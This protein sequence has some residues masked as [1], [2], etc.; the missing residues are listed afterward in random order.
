MYPRG[1][2]V[3][4]STTL[5]ILLAYSLPAM[6]NSN[7]L[8]TTMSHLLLVDCSIIIRIEVFKP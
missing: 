7:S 2:F 4:S 8:S 6:F 3:A 5:N 1:L